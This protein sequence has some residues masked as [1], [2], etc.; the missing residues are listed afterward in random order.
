[1]RS[2]SS[3]SSRLGIEP[4]SSSTVVEPCVEIRMLEL[5]WRYV[6]EIG[7][8]GPTACHARA[9]WQAWRN[10]QAPIGRISP[11]SSATGM[12]WSGVQLAPVDMPAQQRLGTDDAAALR[13]H[14]GLVVQAQLL[15]RQRLA[16]CRLDPSP[17]CVRSFIEAVKKR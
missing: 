5:Q 8:G 17:G 15:A 4:L 6:H 14:L 2:V 7:T 16:Q 1:M 10:T 9:C 3:S 11:L 13:I 12:N